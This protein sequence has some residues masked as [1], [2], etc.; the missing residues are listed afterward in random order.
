MAPSSS[1][2]MIRKLAVISPFMIPKLALC[3][4]ELAMGLP[5]GVTAGTGMDALC[6]WHRDVPVAG[7]QSACRGDRP[8][9]RHARRQSRRARHQGRAGSRR[10]LAD[11]DGGDGRGDGVPEG[12]RRRSLLIPS[13]RR[14]AGP[15]AAS[16]HAQRRGDATVVLRFNAGHVGDK[17]VGCARRSASSPMPICRTSSPAYNQRLGLPGQSAR[18]GRVAPTTC[19]GSSIRS[20]PI[21]VRSPMPAR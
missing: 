14:P 1:S 3:D 15:Q 16:R 8:R 9:R 20:W 6:A 10:A 7:R 11:D 19:P 17:Y 13:A 2:P 21:T 4:P 18:H 12:P 5:P